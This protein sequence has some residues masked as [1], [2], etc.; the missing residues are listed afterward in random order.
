MAEIQKIV[1]SA[2][3]WISAQM[4][5]YQWTLQKLYLKSYHLHNGMQLFRK[6]IN[7]SLA[8]RNKALP[9]Q[10]GKKSGKDPTR[11]VFKL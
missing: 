11:M 3:G 6:S 8:E 1:T 2:A 10:S 4:D 5:P 9:A 7:K